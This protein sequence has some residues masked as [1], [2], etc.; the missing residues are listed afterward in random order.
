[1]FDFQKVV[2][3]FLKVTLSTKPILNAPQLQGPNVN[4]TM[5]WLTPNI[6][7]VEVKK[8]EEKPLINKVM[9]IFVP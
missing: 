6:I 9:L 2:F 1:M 7:N 4:K 8:Y 5:W 3:S